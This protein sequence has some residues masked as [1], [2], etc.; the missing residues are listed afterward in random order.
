[1]TT[2]EL[3][4]ALGVTAAQVRRWR[5][6]GVIEPAVRSNAATG[7][8]GPVTPDL[9]DPEVLDAIRAHLDRK[10]AV[11]RFRKTPEELQESRR[12]AGATARAA[13]EA[14]RQP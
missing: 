14:R 6:L 13:A 7:I 4:V 11:Y 5:E 9:Y 3:A 12:R 8:H 10:R 2:Q 1:M